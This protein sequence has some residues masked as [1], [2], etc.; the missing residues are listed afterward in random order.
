M[1]HSLVCKKLHIHVMEMEDEN[2][3]V[4]ETTNKDGGRH[5]CLNRKFC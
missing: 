2:I 5:S 1:E 4:E 3:I